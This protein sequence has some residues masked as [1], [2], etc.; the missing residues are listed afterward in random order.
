MNAHS[1]HF[2]MGF[3]S[4]DERYLKR[5]ESLPP[6]FIDFFI[7]LLISIYS[8][9]IINAFSPSILFYPRLKTDKTNQYHRKLDAC[10]TCYHHNPND[11]NGMME[12][13]CSSYV[14]LLNKT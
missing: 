14:C 3:Y 6:F 13:V 12:V 7:Y 2:S 4:S 8:S 5:D 1:I 11:R 9:I 10:H